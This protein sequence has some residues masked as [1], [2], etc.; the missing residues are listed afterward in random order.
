M[1]NLDKQ[2]QNYTY[3]KIKEMITNCP[4]LQAQSIAALAYGTGAR[5]SELNRIKKIDIHEEEGYLNI[6]CFVQKK[7]YKTN[8]NQHRIA[9]IRLD[10]TWLIEPINRLLEGKQDN[11]IL[12]PLYRMKIYRILKKEFDFNPH[13]FRALR[14]THLSQLGYSAHKLKHFF[15]WSS[16]APSDSYVGMNTADLKY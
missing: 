5:V 9:I 3:N 10:E 7:R 15:G 8:T 4:N 12:I 14:A 13:F 1:T 16:I 6:N 11:D 2:P